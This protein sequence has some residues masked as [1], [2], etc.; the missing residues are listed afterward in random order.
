MYPDLYYCDI[1]LEICVLIR[2]WALQHDDILSLRR[3]TRKP[4]PTLRRTLYIL[5]RQATL[6]NLIV[7]LS[8]LHYI[9]NNLIFET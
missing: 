5:F 1:F 9:T 6:R 7:F 8:V 2:V 3:E 4:S